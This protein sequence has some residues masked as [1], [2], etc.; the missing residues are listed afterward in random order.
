VTVKGPLLIGGA[1]DKEP[2]E[3][4]LEWVEGPV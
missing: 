2:A 3:W 1:K 4:Q